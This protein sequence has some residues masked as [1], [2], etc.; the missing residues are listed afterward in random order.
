MNAA[1]ACTSCFFPFLQ[2]LIPG[3]I[4]P[5][6]CRKWG[7]ALLMEKKVRSYFTPSL[8]LSAAY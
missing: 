1:K 7:G 4:G 8:L 6:G 3:I 2:K 5:K